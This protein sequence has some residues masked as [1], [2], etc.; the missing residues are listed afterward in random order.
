MKPKDRQQLIT[1]LV[2]E[3]KLNKEQ[4]IDTVASKA[5]VTSATVAKELEELFPDN[6]KTATPATSEPV[7]FTIKLEALTNNAEMEKGRLKE[8][9]VPE[10]EMTETVH[11]ELEKV[12]FDRLEGVKNSKPYVQKFDIRS[13]NN[14]RKNARN[15]GFKYVR[16]LYAPD[17]VDTTVV[18][19]EKPKPVTK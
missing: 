8:Y 6:Q 10:E 14:F 12:A 16:V 3:G 13:W 2:N 4:I 19:R 18:E 1:T 11:V 15:L 5:K 17:G 7:P 9:T